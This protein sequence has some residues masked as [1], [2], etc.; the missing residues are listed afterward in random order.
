MEGPGGWRGTRRPRGCADR[1]CVGWVGPPLVRRPSSLRYKYRPRLLPATGALTLLN[2][3]RL[4]LETGDQVLCCLT[5]IDPT[6]DEEKDGT[7]SSIRNLAE[8][9]VPL[10]PS[11][12]V[13]WP[14]LC[15]LIIIPTRGRSER[16]FYSH[17]YQALETCNAMLP[18]VSFV[19]ATANRF[20]FEIP[21]PVKWVGL[22]S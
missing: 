12:S 7:S 15:R 2:L 20:N 5:G 13:N 10:K 6:A 14:I 21:Y 16:N 18:H 9:Y 3:E 8:A 22:Y 11:T 19:I 17:E 4:D 1:R